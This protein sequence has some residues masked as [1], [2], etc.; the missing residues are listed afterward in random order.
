MNAYLITLLAASLLTIL[1][2]RIAPDGERGGISK[3]VRLIASLFLI[4]VLLSPIQALIRELPRLLEGDWLPNAD[5]TTSDDAYKQRLEDAINQASKDYFT[6]MLEQ[7]LCTELSVTQADLRCRVRWETD[8]Q[9]P[10]PASVTVLLSGGA[11]WKDPTQIRTL[12]SSLIGCP[13]EVVI[14]SRKEN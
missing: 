6:D 2:T 9:T 4:C 14:E 3:H 11:I 12:V 10:K 8:V 7:T 1:V 13:C 5:T